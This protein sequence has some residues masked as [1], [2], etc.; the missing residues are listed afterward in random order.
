MVQGLDFN[1]RGTETCRGSI[2][3]LR[4]RCI[5]MLLFMLGSFL[6]IWNTKC[7]CL[8]GTAK[9]LC[10]ENLQCQVDQFADLLFCVLSLHV[11]FFFMGVGT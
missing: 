11:L 8:F 4:R 3:P 6:I 1:S 2:P 9:F 7:K 5:V 10:H